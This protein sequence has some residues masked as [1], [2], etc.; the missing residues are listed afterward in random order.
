[1]ARRLGKNTKKIPTAS[2]IYGHLKNGAKI[3]F[4]YK[5]RKRSSFFSEATRGDFSKPKFA[6]IGPAIQRYE[7]LLYVF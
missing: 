7:L 3:Q 6:K 2:N 1:M 5:T 4:F